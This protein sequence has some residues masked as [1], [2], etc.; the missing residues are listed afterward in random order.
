[1][2][3]VSLVQPGVLVRL[4]A[5]GI[6]AA[7]SLSSAASAQTDKPHAAPSLWLPQSS[8][9]QPED[10]GINSHTHLIGLVLAERGVTP[11][12]PS[13][14]S[15]IAPTA[16]PRA[17]YYYETPA[18]L[19]CV[20]GLTTNTSGCNP[21]TVTAVAPSSGSPLS[22][23]IVDA[24]D[25]TK[26]T[27]DLATFDSQFGLPAPKF[28]VVYASGSRPKADTGWALESS[29]DVEYAHAM[30]PGAKL[31]LVEA[32]SN[33]NSDLLTAVDK[34]ASL[35]AADGG[36]IV[37]MSWGESEWSS[38]TAYDSHFQ[39]SGV[40]FVASTGDAPGVSWPS[41]SAYAVAAGGTSISRNPATGTFIS[42]GTWQLAGLVQAPT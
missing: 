31:Y 4:V 41:V 38:E 7:G 19:A 17:G 11:P 20:Y 39:K 22:I 14:S 34:A 2:N 24:Y 6:A 37:S 42:E 8:L 36:G 1:M 3:K 30:S 23:A 29:L 13:G 40:T 21:N 15:G 25:N 18:S 27:T 33:S 12:N 10:I 28:Q 26:I 32:A 9:Q 5:L 16:A 35:V